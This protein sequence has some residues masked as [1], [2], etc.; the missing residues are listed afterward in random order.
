MRAFKLDSYLK[1]EGWNKDEVICINVRT[2]SKI[3]KDYMVGEKGF[4][5]RFNYLNS[6]NLM[7]EG[8][9]VGYRASEFGLKSSV[10]KIWS[11]NK[12]YEVYRKVA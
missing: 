1:D 3:G 11:K 10:L 2:K 8:V 5:N 9:L 12:I 7:I 6:G 4:K